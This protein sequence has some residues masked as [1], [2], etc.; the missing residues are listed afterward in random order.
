MRERLQKLI[1][2]SGLTSRR[3]A[4]DWI[5]QGRVAVN[6]RTAGL[7]DSADPACDSVTIDGRP[8][9]TAPAAIVVLL[10]KPRGYLCSLDDPQGRPL[11]TDLVTS[12]PHRLYPVGRLDFDSEGLLLLTNDGELAHRLM[13]PRH[14]VAKCY[15]VEV[16]GRLSQEDYRHLSQGIRLEDGMTSPAEVKP[17]PEGRQGS[18]FEITLHEGRNR[19]VRRMCEALGKKVDRLQRVRLAFLRLGGLRPGH[20]RILKM[21]EIERLKGG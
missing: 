2:R 6:G 16:R 7:G 14:H 18:R 5:A 3:K 8:L 4:E 1:A 19:Q 11:V 13:H 10:N 21:A 12:L 17:L 15:R 9:Q 20:F